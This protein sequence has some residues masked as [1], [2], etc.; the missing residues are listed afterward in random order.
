MAEIGNKAFEIREARESEENMLTEISFASKK[1]W[2]YPPEYLKIWEPELTI[3]KNYLSRNKVFVYESDKEILAFYSIV[4]LSEPLILEEVKI[5]KGVWL[6]HMFVRPDQIGKGIGKRLFKHLTG[7][8]NENSIGEIKILVDP[9]AKEFYRK[10]GCKYIKEYPSTIKN[11]TVP[12]MI[13][14]VNG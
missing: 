2:N 12:M 11:R 13:F 14:R 9:N 8:C 3:T 5:E 6:D 7:Y 4:N 10:M 1:Y